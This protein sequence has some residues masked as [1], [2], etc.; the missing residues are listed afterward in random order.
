MK[1][2]APLFPLAIC[3]MAGIACSEQQASWR[4]LVVVLG[5]LLAATVLVRRWARWQTAGI[6]A[7]IFVSGMAWGSRRYEQLDA[8]WP[9]E[10]LPQE[11]VV[12]AEP[13]WKEK[14]VVVDVM[15][16]DGNDKLR[17]RIA[18]DTLSEAIAIGD[19]LELSTN[20]NKVRAWKRGPFSYRRYMQSH[21]FA[22]EAFV[23]V[24]QWQW[25]DVPLNGL[26]AVDRLRLRF[27]CW[28][29]QLLQYYRQW[30]F[31]DDIYGVV[32]AMALGDRSSLDSQVRDTYAQAGA[33][34]VLA[35]SGLHLMIIYT[36]ISF[37]VGFR[38]FRILSQVL[39]V[40]A[41]WAFA[42][43]VGL[44]PSV[45]RAAFMVTVYAILSLGYRD[46]MSVNTLAFTAIVML[47]ANPL[48]LYDM[49]FQLSFLSVLS[50]LLFSPF[51]DSIVPPHVLQRHRWLGAVWGLATVSVSAQLGTAPLVA[52]F[53]GRLPV[54]FL[55]SN[56]VV[57]PMVTLILYLALASLVTGWSALAGYVAAALAWVVHATNSLLGYIARLP[58]CTIEG[59]EPTVL[60]VVCLYIIIGC[61]WLLLMV[62]CKKRRQRGWLLG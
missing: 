55:L 62:S 52:Y 24:W 39:I 36:V 9:K 17:C 59:L 14:W 8:A 34:H 21:G 16:A 19:G 45:T 4:V 2:H 32:A 33:S 13:V 40:L 23:N 1:W 56:F 12:I 30:H 50:I 6:Y 15:T 29:H 44:S 58:G 53:F 22:G 48:A 28:R 51:F 49:G 37:F 57:I 41:I 20:I 43:L 11:V 46:R 60:Q 25:K 26:S 3:L 61:V 35:L 18:R 10:P 42:F 47:V 5:V 38:R 31:E 54:Y 27:L 7:C